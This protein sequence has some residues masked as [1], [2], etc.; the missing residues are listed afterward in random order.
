M[1]RRLAMFKS[2]LTLYS[3]TKI[4]GYFP[5]VRYHRVNVGIKMWYVHYYSPYVGLHLSGQSFTIAVA[6]L[7]WFRN[8]H[9]SIGMLCGNFQFT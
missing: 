8:G 2:D 1:L 6:I 3:P 5:H 9:N 7:P 4:S